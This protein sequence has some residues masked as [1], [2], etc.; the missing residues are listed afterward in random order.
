MYA[1]R[2]AIVKL[3]SQDQ[4]LEGEIERSHIKTDLPDLNLALSE[5]GLFEIDWSSADV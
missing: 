3:T 2:E 1:M 4:I 5:L